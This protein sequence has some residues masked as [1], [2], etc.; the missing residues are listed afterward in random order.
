MPVTPPSVS[1]RRIALLAL[2][3][4]CQVPTDILDRTYYCDGTAQENSCG[5]THD[6]TQ[7]ACYMARQVGVKDFCTERCPGNDPNASGPGWRCVDT[8]AQLRTCRPSDTIKPCSQPGTNCLRTDA[9]EDEGVCLPMDTCSSNSDCKDATR[10]ACMNALLKDWYGPNSPIKVDHSSCLRTGCM[11]NLAACGSGETCLP[12]VIPAGSSPL[13]ICVPN[14]DANLNCPANYFCLRKLGGPAQ[15]AVCIPGLLGFRCQ[16][17]M[18]CLIG[19][20]L[21][22][23]DG[24]SVCAS[25]CQTHDDCAGF[26]NTRGTFLCAADPAGSG[27]RCQNWRAFVGSNCLSDFDCRPHELCEF[28]SPYFLS[29]TMFTGE[30]RPRC[31]PEQPCVDRAGVPHVCVDLGGNKTCYP[32]AVHLPCQDDSNCIGGLICREV[33]TPDVNGQPDR[34]RRCTAPCQTDEDCAANRFA[35]WVTY[36][37]EGLCVDGLDAGD[38]CERDNQCL[39]SGCKLSTVAAEMAAGVKRCQP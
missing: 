12:T 6:G 37:T 10:P 26:G 35:G 36:C 29:K 21:N 9:L 2:T 5:T 39:V 1:L 14:C 17:D 7:M 30:C 3:L 4:A 38:R 8:Q 16:T 27:K 33:T 22:T 11:K 24:F 20:C 31:G 19:K 18:D 32:G 13:D 23:G 28:Q 25:A 15:P 34:R